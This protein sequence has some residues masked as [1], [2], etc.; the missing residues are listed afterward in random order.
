M[1]QNTCLTKLFI[2]WY[3]SHQYWWQWSEMKFFRPF[4]LDTSPVFITCYRLLHFSQSMR[5]KEKKKLAN[6]FSWIITQLIDWRKREVK[7]LFFGAYNGLLIQKVKLWS[8]V[9]TLKR[10]LPFAMEKAGFLWP[11]QPHFKA[12]IASTWKSRLQSQSCLSASKVDFFLMTS[13]V[14]F[15]IP[16]IYYSVFTAFKLKFVQC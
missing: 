3:V 8:G 4:N 7:Y 10:D 16:F 5:N 13:A 2:F 9:K 11:R 12:P 1:Q 6:F 15:S 14:R